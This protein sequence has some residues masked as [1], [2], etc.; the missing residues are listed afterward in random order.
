MPLL[1]LLH[2]REQ[3]IATAHSPSPL[4]GSSCTLTLL[5]M[6]KVH[7]ENIL[8]L[9]H[10]MLLHVKTTAKKIN[11]AILAPLANIYTNVDPKLPYSQSGPFRCLFQLTAVAGKVQRSASTPRNIT[12]KQAL[13]IQIIPRS[14]SQLSVHATLFRGRIGPSVQPRSRK[15]YTRGVKLTVK[16]VTPV[17]CTQHQSSH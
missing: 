14:T 17:S 10:G 1:V 7:A 3:E 16:L 15:A 4:T 13:N 9:T 5:T 8:S 11:E 12:I 2:S 6:C